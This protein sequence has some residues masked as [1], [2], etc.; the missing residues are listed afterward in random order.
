[1]MI[2]RPPQHGQR[3]IGGSSTSVGWRR[4]RGVQRL[5]RCG[6]ENEAAGNHD[7]VFDLHRFLLD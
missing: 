6:A 3:L 5:N 4:A 2:M 7:C 1:M